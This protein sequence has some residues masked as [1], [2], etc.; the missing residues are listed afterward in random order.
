MPLP[1]CKIC[2]HSTRL[3]IDSKS[4]KS[5]Y[6]CSHCDFISIDQKHLL[7]KEDEEDRYKQHNNTLEN[8]GYV[9]MLNEFI[10]SS[11]LP[12][13]S[14]IKTS[15][16]F[17]CG[18]TPALA[19]LLKEKGIAVD[20]YDKFFSSDKVYINKKYDLI[21]ATE[22]MEHLNDPIETIKLLRSLL[23]DNGILAIM[24][25]FHPCND[26]EFLDWWYRRDNTHISFY[27]LNTI[28]HLA[29]AFN[30]KMIH[31]DEK[32]SCVLKAIKCHENC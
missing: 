9:N 19:A 15:L 13:H 3:I 18:N 17:G 12:F 6:S 11:I 4:D 25:N 24:T 23:N 31:Y 27:T 29:K 30:I 5:Y 10:S 7:S 20:T 21:T 28:R 32:N 16:D 22:V 14:T 1:S 26:K 8:E 2:S